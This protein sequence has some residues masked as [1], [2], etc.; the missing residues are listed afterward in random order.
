MGTFFTPIYD[1]IWEDPAVWIPYSFSVTA[2]LALLISIVAIFLY[3][4]RPFQANVVR[5]GIGM[6][7]FALGFVVGVLF[8]L[9]GIGTYLWQEAIGVFLM[10]LALL[11]QFLAVRSIKKD[12]ELV[13]SMDRI[14]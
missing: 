2:T 12:E 11:A 1:R 3:N 8:S 14:R 7:F 13:K 6:Q 4:N 9:G 5:G 10:L